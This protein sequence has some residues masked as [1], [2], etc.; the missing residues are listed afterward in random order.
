MVYGCSYRREVPGTQK[1]MNCLRVDPKIW[2]L[3][4]LRTF[5]FTVFANG[6]HCPQVMI[7]PSLTS[8]AGEQCTEMLLC[9]FS[10]RL[11]FLMKCKY[12]LRRM[13]VRFILV[14]M[15]M[16]FRIL[17]RMLTLPVNGHF[18]STNFPSL[19]SEGTLKP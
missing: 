10:K 13:I 19:A 2:F 6:R 5:H 18:L 4:T 8:K 15:H 14:E 9:L 11:Y 1:S 16:P 3:S 17:P 7:S 12:F